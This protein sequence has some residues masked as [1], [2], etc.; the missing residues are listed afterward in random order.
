MKDSNKIS[1]PFFIVSVSIL[2]LND[3]ILKPGFHNDLTG[4]LSD[5]AGLFAFP[6]FLSAL[7]PSQVKRIHILTGI[8]FVFWKSEWSQP[9]IE[10]IN[11][12]STYLQSSRLF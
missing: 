6:F 7:I 10:L 12:M 8:L 1:S 2:I 3:W 5:F 11:W 4:K 9:F